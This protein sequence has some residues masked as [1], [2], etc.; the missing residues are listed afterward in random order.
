[1]IKSCKE[2]KNKCCKRG[3]GPYKKVDVRTY[4]DTFC[5]HT[6]YNL[7]CEN[8]DEET[9]ECKVWGT[10]LLPVACST[11]V[12]HQRRYTKKELKFIAEVEV[13]Q[14]FD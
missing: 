13:A 11:F 8:L 3:P 4:L 7:M 5:H 10:L 9:E 2:C 14:E 6:G 1:M 12:C